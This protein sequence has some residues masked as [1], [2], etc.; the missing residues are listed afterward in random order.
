MTFCYFSFSK[1]R[2]AR[3][4]GRFLFME[5]NATVFFFMKVQQTE[6]AKVNEETTSVEMVQ[7]LQLM[8]N[9]RCLTGEGFGPSTSS[10]CRI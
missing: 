8:G 10:S 5:S 4:N 7:T 9:L 3:E 2:F 6:T 1:A